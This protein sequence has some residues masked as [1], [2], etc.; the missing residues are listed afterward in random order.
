MERKAK[1]GMSAMMIIA[2]TFIAIGVIFLP[3]GV[4]TFA[5]VW[6]IGGEDLAVSATFL[7][8]TIIGLVFLIIGS[9]FLAVEMQKRRTSNRLLKEGY[10]II[11]EV[12]SVD[13]NW[14]VSYGKHGHP[15]VIR[16]KYDDGSGAIHI[17]KSRNILVYPGSNL[18]G[19]MVRVYLDRN[20]SD[21]YKHYYM[22]VDAI[23]Q[24]VVEH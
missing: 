10:Y 9:A 24:K 5:M 20:A 1:M 7:V 3:V 18:E 4:G 11:T 8:F 19:Q 21:V 16:S 14:N 2:I 15:Y 22:D 17:F 12:V 23:L 6:N 13:R